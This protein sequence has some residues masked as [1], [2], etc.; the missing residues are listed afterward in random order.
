MAEGPRVKISEGQ[1]T[2]KH[3]KGLTRALRSFFL[4]DGISGRENTT[5]EKSFK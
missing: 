2:G 3:P 1:G 4:L 5:P